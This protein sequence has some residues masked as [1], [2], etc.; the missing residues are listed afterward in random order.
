MASRSAAETSFA[1]IRCVAARISTH[2]GGAAAHA[3]TGS[4]AK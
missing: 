1:S 3:R 2:A 4:G